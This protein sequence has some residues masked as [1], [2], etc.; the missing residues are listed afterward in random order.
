MDEIDSIP[1][2]FRVRL[3]ERFDLA[4]PAIH[5]RFDSVDGTRRYL[6]RLADGELVE[7]ALIPEEERATFCIST[8]VG[9][10]LG[11]AFCL[12]A[13]LG[14]TRNLS[15]AEIVA[16]V[17]TLDRDN[18]ERGGPG[19]VSVV[20]MGMGE[21]LD[22][23]DETMTA[24]RILEDRCGLGLPMSR[25]TVSTVGLVPGIRRLAGE[26]LFPNLS[27]SLTGSRNEARSALMPVNRKYPIDAVMREAR[28]LPPARQKRVMFEY[29]LIEGL[30]D[31]EPDA[32]ELARLL[33]G[34][35]V[36]V[37]LIPL[38]PA[39][40]IPFSRPSDAAILAFQRALT[41]R[42]VHTFIRKNRGGD[43]SS[44]CGQ[45]KRRLE[46]SVP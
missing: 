28:A 24:I 45:L 27:I 10:A 2:A 5:K 15:A 4:L 44:A 43:V 39:P 37:N 22:N 14:L 17:V 38:N 13:Q 12:T 41:S 7:S 42:G 34:M 9:C 31:S 46:A 8:Q 16:Q 35:R 40:E 25:I 29:V 30:T 32:I 21:P 26:P 19:R 6:L 1:P 20:F 23:Y 3:A 18:R 11:C 33:E 36:K